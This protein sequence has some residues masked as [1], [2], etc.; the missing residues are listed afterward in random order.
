M[1]SIKAFE[2]L[3]G[4]ISGLCTLSGKL[5]CFG[6]LSGKLSAVIDFNA[7]SG[8]YEVVPN[9]FNTQVL[10][11]A[12]KVLKKDIVVQ[13]VPYFETVTTMMGLRFILQ[14]RL[15]KMPNQNVNKV[16]YGGRVLIDLTGDTVDPSKLLKGSKAHDKS[17]A[18]IEGACTFDVDSTDATA[19]AAEILFGKTAYVSGNKLT[20]TMKNN[21]AVTK[22]IT[23]RDEEVTIPQGF[24][25]GSGKVGIDATEK[26]KLI[27]NN[28]RE[29]V[30]ILGVEG[31]MS[32]SENMKPQAK[33]VTPSTAKQTILP[34]TEYNCLSQVEVEAIPYVEADNPAGGVTVTIAG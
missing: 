5:T 25:D 9:A 20:G 34:D 4:H 28:I 21:G 31:T 16:I 19:V 32:G 26:G 33:T 6:S 18:Q 14:R 30:T 27:A 11:T 12:N 10:P 23:T 17:G 2:C 24:H 29:G 3:T 8:E 13:K 1:S 7:Y 15:I 22:K